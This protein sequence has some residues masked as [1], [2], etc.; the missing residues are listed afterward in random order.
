MILLGIFLAV[1]FVYSLASKRARNTVLTAPILFTAV[2]IMAFLVLPDPSQAVID[3]KTALVV[4]EITL[5][6]VLFAD[7]THIN[8][9]RVMRQHQLPGRLLGVGMPLAILAGAIA[10]LILYPAFSFWEAAILATILAPT[11][12]SLGAAIVH[13]KRV[14]ARIRQALSVESGL[15]DGLS[16]PLLMLF[17]ALAQ[18]GS[19]GEDRSWLVFT[20]RQIGFGLLV[21][22]ILGWLGGWL[23]ANAKGRSWMTKAAEQLSLLALAIFSWWL[24]EKMVG[25]NGFI[26]AFTAGAIVRRG[27]ESAHQRM[28]EFSEAWGDLLIYFIFFYFGLIAA[29]ELGGLTGS[30]WI[31]AILSLTL[32]RM[33]PVG[34]SLLGTKLHRSSVI[35]L[36]WFG[37]RGL[38]SIVLGLV[39][40]QEKA[41]LPGESLIELAIIATVLLSVFAHGISA[42][43]AIGLYARQVSRFEV[44]SPELQEAADLESAEG[45]M[46]LL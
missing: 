42:A 41:H 9:R 28:A 13:S 25:G 16:I 30:L 40:L 14:P 39:F 11:D 2:G 43:P 27:F 34:L 35:F 8:L 36:G 24:A 37:P 17:I 31:Y 45:A 15:N 1:V 4:G 46:E 21:G 7:A 33:L 22:L 20:A 32:V 38:A 26:A 6:L 10:A 18:V 44:D 12:A 29:P 5:A 19:P 23:V 3:D